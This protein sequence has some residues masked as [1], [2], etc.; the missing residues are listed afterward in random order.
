MPTPPPIVTTDSAQDLKR[1]AIA[2][3][4]WMSIQKHGPEMEYPAAQLSSFDWEA[5]G[6]QI[7]ETDDKGATLVNWMLHNWRR[8]TVGNDFIFERPVSQSA[9]AILAVF[10]GGSA[11]S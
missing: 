3:E 4:A 5:I 10:S 2:L 11:H 8:S 9:R 6:G 1:I 7:V